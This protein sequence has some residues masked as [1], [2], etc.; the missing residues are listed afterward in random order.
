MGQFVGDYEIKWGVALDPELDG[1]VKVTILATGFGL[2]DVEGMNLHLGKK[3]SAEDERKRIEED[4]INARKDDRR[5][6]Y[7]GDDKNSH[8]SKKRYNIFIFEPED[9]NNEDIILAVENS[10]TYDRS[11]MV[12]QN[13]RSQSKSGMVKPRKEEPSQ[14]EQ[15]II[16][17]D[18]D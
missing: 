4:E 3:R 15:R 18:A 1:K 9:L 11:R 6:R 13:I 7:Y 2:N 5:T 14:P 8:D 12:V 16:N 10:P 17:F